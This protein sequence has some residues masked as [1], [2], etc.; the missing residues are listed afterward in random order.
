M[1]NR[2]PCEHNNERNAWVADN[3]A[4]LDMPFLSIIA[5]YNKP[6]ESQ[7]HIST[8]FIT[9]L[10]NFALLPREKTGPPKTGVAGPI[11]PALK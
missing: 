5:Y 7:N 10:L 6:N 2:V 4:P 8:L 1:H 3:L 9:C 11:P